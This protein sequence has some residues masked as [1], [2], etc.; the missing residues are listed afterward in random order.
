MT[1]YYYVRDDG[2]SSSGGTDNGFTSTRRTGGSWDSIMT[3]TTD[4]YPNIERAFND[5]TT[6]PVAGDYIFVS[7]SSAWSGS[8]AT[9]TGLY[10]AADTTDSSPSNP[11]Y[12]ICIDDTNIDNISTGASESSTNGTSTIR[13]GG[14]LYWYGIDISSYSNCVHGFASSASHQGHITIINSTFTVPQTGDT[15]INAQYSSNSIFYLLNCNIVTGNT[16]NLPIYV[17]DGNIVIW[18]GGTLDCSTAVPN[19]FCS[20]GNLYGQIHLRNIDMST[21]S[22]A[23]GFYSG[24]ADGGLITMRGCKIASDFPFPNIDRPNLRFE[25][26]N[27]DVGSGDKQRFYISDGLGSAY[28]VDSTDSQPYVS[29]ET[30]FYDGSVK[31]SIAVD[32]NTNCSV[33][34]PFYFNLPSQYIDLTSASS[35]TLT[36][37]LTS[38]DTIDDRDIGIYVD[39]FDATNVYP[40]KTEVSNSTK[41]RIPYIFTTGSSMTDD[42]GAGRW[43]NGKTYQYSLPVTITDGDESVPTIRVEF[44][45]NFTNIVYIATEMGLS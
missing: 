23:T 25:M 18:D 2:T 31:S 8:W 34:M 33:S 12:V 22:G 41:L 29:N 24:L 11:L 1:N 40:C 17:D 19:Y 16:S 13:F 14:N 7:D 42:S 45:K 6:A 38:N 10:F 30:A 20:I 4:Y 37:Y 39:Y 5:S 35:D 26:Y 21:F 27:C 32:T 44:Y 28:N 3:A 9:N 43:T 15:A 36:F